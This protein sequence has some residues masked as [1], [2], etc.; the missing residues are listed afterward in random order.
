MAV[1]TDDAPRTSSTGLTLAGPGPSWLAIRP[2]NG[3]DIWALATTIPPVRRNPPI[4]VSEHRMKNLPNIKSPIL[5]G[6]Y[7][8]PPKTIQV[9]HGAVTVGVT[10]GVLVLVLLED[11]P[12]RTTAA[13]TARSEEHTSEL[14]SP[15][16][17]V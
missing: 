6:N 4:T 14:Q 13:A 1:R 10:G 17:L 9:E 16:N 12:F 2:N 5:A 8:G 15:C 11:L 7:F 3:A